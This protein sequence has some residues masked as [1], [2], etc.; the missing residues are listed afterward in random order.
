[1]RNFIT[2]LVLNL[3][4]LRIIF[5]NFLVDLYIYINI[6]FSYPIDTVIDPDGWEI[7]YGLT[8]V[9]PQYSNGTFASPIQGPRCFCVRKIVGLSVISCPL[10]FLKWKSYVPIHSFFV[11]RSDLKFNQ[12]ECMF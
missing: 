2:G 7:Y 10:S 5:F 8:L 11:R 12:T 4:V 1:M 6:I 3:C 9:T